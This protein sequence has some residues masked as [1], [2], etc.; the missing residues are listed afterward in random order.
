VD[1]LKAWYRSQIHDWFF[2]SFVGPA[3]TKNAVHGA[4]QEA[5]DQWKRDLA[6]RKQWSRDQR[7]QDHLRRR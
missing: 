1:K 4:S 7:R 6:A 5:R 3:Q 2:R